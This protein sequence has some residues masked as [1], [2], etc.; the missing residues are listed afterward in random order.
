M[1]LVH[2]IVFT[3]LLH[4]KDNVV[5][6]SLYHRLV[7]KVMQ[8]LEIYGFVSDNLIWHCAK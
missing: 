6:N 7:V 1:L 8:G 5:C 2:I 3:I 4:C